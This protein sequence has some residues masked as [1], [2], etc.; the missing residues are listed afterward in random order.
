MC[1]DDSIGGASCGSAG[2]IGNWALN[3][4]LRDLISDGFMASLPIDPIND[5]V[6]KYTYEPKNS[7]E[8]GYPGYILTANLETGGSFIIRK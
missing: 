6:Y 4:D 2:V 8:V 5:S 1:T 7:N 3:S